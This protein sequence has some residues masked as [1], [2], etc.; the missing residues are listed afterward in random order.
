MQNANNCQQQGLLHAEGHPLAWHTAIMAKT[1]LACSGHLEPAK[2][3]Y[4][5]SRFEMQDHVFNLHVNFFIIIL[6]YL[7][8]II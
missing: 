5:N 3:V 8:I 1:L 7:G 4:G 2:N 6:F